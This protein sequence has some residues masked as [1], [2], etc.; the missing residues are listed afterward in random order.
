MHDRNLESGFLNCRQVH[1]LYTSS[2][3]TLRD[4][5]HAVQGS[6]VNGPGN[7]IVSTSSSSAIHEV[8]RPNSN[9]SPIHSHAQL[10]SRNFS[11]KSK[12]LV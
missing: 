12:L 1:G 9:Q 6:M 11:C 10:R 4:G 5:Q 7:N 8:C 3:Q 2:H